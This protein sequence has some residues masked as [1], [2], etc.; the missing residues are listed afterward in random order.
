VFFDGLRTIKGI[1]RINKNLKL[2]FMKHL[3]FFFASPFKITMHILNVLN[4]VVLSTLL[5]VFVHCDSTMMD[6]DFVL[7]TNQRGRWPPSH[8]FL[9]LARLVVGDEEKETGI[10]ATGCS[11]RRKLQW[12][13]KTKT[14]V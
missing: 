11:R 12:Q 5:L 4:L 14:T 7:E 9:I 8:P 2:S 13:K 10:L 1:L 6:F 3:V